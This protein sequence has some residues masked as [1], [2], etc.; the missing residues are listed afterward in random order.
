[1]Q[2]W[3][4]GLTFVEQ[5]VDEADRLLAESFQDWLLRVMISIDSRISHDG[6]QDEECYARSSRCSDFLAPTHLPKI[7]SDFAVGA[8]R[9][10]QTSC[11][12]L[13]FSAT[14]TRDPAIV[15]KLHLRNAKYILVQSRDTQQLQPIDGTCVE[16]PENLIVS[17]SRDFMTFSRN[18]LA[19]FCGHQHCL[20]AT[21]SLSPHLQV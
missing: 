8:S 19:T 18:M 12:K 10:P 6:L 3:Y 16:M 2:S 5:V 1:M 4:L 11:Q 13:L 7:I 20:E 9:Q 15:K 17:A 14:L 21:G